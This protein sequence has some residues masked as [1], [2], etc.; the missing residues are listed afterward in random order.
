MRVFRSKCF[1]R[2][3]RDKAVAIEKADFADYMAKL[4]DAAGM[5]ITSMADVKEA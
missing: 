5:K 2:G 1:P 4:G 3:V